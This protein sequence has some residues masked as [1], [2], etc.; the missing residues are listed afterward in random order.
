MRLFNRSLFVWCLVVVVSLTVNAPRAWAQGG[1][2]GTVADLSLPNQDASD[3]VIEQDALG[4]GFAVW[5]TNTEIWA[6]HRPPGAREWGPPVLLQNPANPPG[7]PTDPDLVVDGAGNAV[8]VWGR[9]QGGGFGGILEYARYL[10]GGINSWTQAAT[11]P[12]V[13]GLYPEVV[14]DSA[15]RFTVVWHQDVLMTIFEIK[16]RRFTPGLGW[17]GVL[18]VGVSGNGAS[19]SDDR[20]VIDGDGHAWFVWTHFNTAVTPNQYKILAARFDSAAGTWSAEV[21]LAS[22]QGNGHGAHLTVDS[23]GNVT[24]I[25]PQPEGNLTDTRLHFARF[26]KAAGIWSAASP[27]P[28]TLNAEEERLTTLPDGDVLGIWSAPFAGGEVVQVSRYDVATSQ[29]TLPDTLSAPGGDADA[30]DIDVDAAGNVFA[31]WNRFNGAQ[32]VAQAARLDAATGSWSAVTDLGL[33]GDDGEDVQVAVDDA[34][35]A[36]I[37]WEFEDNGNDK[38]QWTEW[39]AG[40]VVPVLQPP[41]NLQLVSINGNTVT[42]AWAVAPGSA[43]PAGFVLEG[44]IAPGEVLASLPTGSAAPTF[45]FVAPNGAFYVRMHALDATTRSG[46]SNEIRIFVNV[47]SPPGAP[48]NLTGTAVGTTLTLNWSNNPTGGAADAVILDVTGSIAASF[49][50]PGAPQSF[51]FAGVPAG[52]YTFTV[53]AINATGNSAPSNPI[54]LTFPGACDAPNAPTE[55]AS[56]VEGGIVTLNWVAPLGGGPA[57]TYRIEAGSAPGLADLATLDTGSAATTFTT[58]APP[59]TYHVRVRATNACGVST[60]SADI[61]VIVP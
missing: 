32:E 15:G 27:V 22:R 42:L 11:V 5:M 6:S 34:G 14:L 23:V 57:A 56:L 26:D 35:N 40:Q 7:E 29:W 44:G 8:V 61:T 49:N 2:T 48:Q 25:W 31:V 47:P 30:G 28:G 59:G 43:A 46:A 4:N 10:G 37:G 50:L 21:T 33:M 12:G 36:I 13:N 45:T 24:A 19:G 17:G 1:F 16:S 53:R 58:A 54:T 60:P 41:V 9:P 39:V 38:V 52:T 18:D 55:L 3:L 20:F 51:S